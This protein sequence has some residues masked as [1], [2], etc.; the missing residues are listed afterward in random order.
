MLPVNI[1]CNVKRCGM[2][3]AERKYD[4]HTGLDLY[5]KEKEPVKCMRDGKVVDVFQFTGEKVGSPWWNTT[6]AVVVE[7]E[8]LIFVYGEILPSVDIGELVNVGKTLGEVLPVLKVDK[9]VTPTS[10]LHLEVWDKFHYIKNFTWL[11]GEGK[12]VGLCNPLHFLSANWTGMWLIK[13]SMGYRLE[14]SVGDYIRFFSMAAD[15]KAYCQDMGIVS[16]Y[17]KKDSHQDIKLNYT[18]MT[19]KTLWFDE[20]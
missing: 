3:S 7:S 13:T 11:K 9:G 5:C 12:P 17:L 8:G 10:M 14:S 19:K 15:C 1:L 6:F 2:F 16:K 20:E 4:I 18:I